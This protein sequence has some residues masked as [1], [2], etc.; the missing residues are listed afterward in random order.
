M[1]RGK[2]KPKDCRSDMIIGL[3]LQ[4]DST[5]IGELRLPDVFIVDW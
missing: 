5:W 1:F 3:D 4:N 2:G